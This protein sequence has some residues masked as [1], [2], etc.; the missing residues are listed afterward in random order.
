M[1]TIMN[2]VTGPATAT[3]VWQVFIPWKQMNQESVFTFEGIRINLIPFPEKVER[4]SIHVGDGP[5]GSVDVLANTN[6]TGFTV[7]F[8]FST[9][10]RD[11]PFFCLLFNASAANH[12]RILRGTK[13]K[14]CPGGF[15]PEN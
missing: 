15:C 7:V 2:L 11:E 3:T 8:Y 5:I 13:L 10:I 12:A 14:P 6:L 1:G 9:L 4:I